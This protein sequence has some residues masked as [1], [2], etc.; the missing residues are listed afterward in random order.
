MSWKFPNDTLKDKHIITNESLNDGFMPA[1]S[2]A[3]GKLNE[4]NLAQGI[5]AGSAFGGGGDL[6]VPDTH[7]ASSSFGLEFINTRGA[8]QTAAEGGTGATRGAWIV[9]DDV[10]G[11]NNSSDKPALDGGISVDILPSWNVLGNKEPPFQRP[12]G[13]NQA[14]PMQV[15]FFAEESM[16]VWIMAS[17]Q[18]QDQFALGQMFCLRV[19][20]VIIAE[21]IS[22]SADLVND[23]IDVQGYTTSL[24][25]AEVLRMSPAA[26][27]VG[28]E[29]G[30][31]ACV[32]CVIDI[33]PG[34][35]KV[36]VLAM[37]A[38]SAK[39]QPLT[40]AAPSTRVCVGSR[41]III[42]KMMR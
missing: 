3:Q 32:E 10:P 1:A 2:E 30:Y 15:T 35:T 14:R 7:V 6:F 40:S 25:A 19:N 13:E 29:L 17:M 37:N 33:P 36:E 27:C 42:L 39:G 41:E 28:D 24:P 5:V 34:D 16:S 23:K 20:G 8:N 12:V 18:V 26:G 11:H 38:I 9:I 4:H 22:G 31:P 21:S